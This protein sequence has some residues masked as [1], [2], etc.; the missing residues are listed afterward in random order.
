MPTTTPCLWFD[1]QGE[2]AAQ[3][4]TSVF[5]NSQILNVTRYGSAGPRPEGTVMTVT[6]ELD[7][8]QFLALNGGPNFTF[9]EAISFEIVCA[10][11]KEVDHYWNGLVADGG[12]HGPCGW[13]KDRFGV[14]WQ[15]VPQRL[16]ELIG[17]GSGERA[18]RVMAALM[19]M[20][21]LDV[22]ELEAAAQG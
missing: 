13:L 14:S 18:Q 17:D 9:S 19:T 5:P 21:K 3:H 11:Q 7:G 15:V 6:F 12:E 8:Q 10:D 22:A 4:Y 1:T 16:T 2:E 20:G